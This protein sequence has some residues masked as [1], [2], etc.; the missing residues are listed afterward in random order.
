VV[1]VTPEVVWHTTTGRVAVT[2]GTDPEP[3]VDEV[4]VELE[5]VVV[6]VDIG[7]AVVEVVC[8]GW[9]V[10][11]VELGPD[12]PHA[13]STTVPTTTAPANHKRCDT[14]APLTTA[15]PSPTQPSPAQ[16][17]PVQPAQ[18]YAST[19]RSANRSANRRCAAA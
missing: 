14:D 10:E 16:P 7:R 3:P 9:V 8:F 1:V 13:A 18:P 6:D 15:Q 5:L 11:L 12:D 2:I 4:D 19:V 17:S